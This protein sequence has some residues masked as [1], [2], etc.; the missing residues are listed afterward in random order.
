MKGPGSEDS[1]K[2]GPAFPGSFRAIGLP[3]AL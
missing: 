3:R 2:L 1:A